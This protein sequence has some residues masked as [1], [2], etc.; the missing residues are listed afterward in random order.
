MGDQWINDCMI[1][2]MES[3]AFDTDA[4]MERFRNMKS[5]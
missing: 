1:T 5:R 4:I 2:Y 3:D